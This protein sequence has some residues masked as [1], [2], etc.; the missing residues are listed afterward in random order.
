LLN[1]PGTTSYDRA[2]PR[3]GADARRPNVLARAD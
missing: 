3:P 2:P 1:R